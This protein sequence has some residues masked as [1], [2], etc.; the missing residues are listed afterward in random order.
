MK[1][2]WTSRSKA[3]V[4][5]LAVTAMTTSAGPTPASAADSVSAAGPT[6]SFGV[7][8][9]QLNTGGYL[10][11][12]AI[13]NG[14]TANGASAI[15][16]YY[17]PYNVENDL[18]IRTVEANGATRFMPKHTDSDDQNP[19][20][21]KCLAVQGA[22][23]DNYAKIVN[24][25]CTYDL[26]N[27]DVWFHH[28]SFAGGYRSYRNQHSGKCMVVQGA[29]TNNGAAIIQYDCNGAPNSAWSYEGPPN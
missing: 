25:T 1:T 14:S 8:K 10:K 22:S 20:N 19:F 9:T 27:N 29:S 5:A 18:V 2:C 17:E 4:A 13:Q 15:L 26:V 6:T 11:V 28:G 16:Y 24:A 7:L 23:K 12:I 3:L 21:D